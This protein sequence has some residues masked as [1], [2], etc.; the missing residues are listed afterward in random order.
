MSFALSGL[1]LYTMWVVLA[2]IA[3]DFLVT[4]YVSVQSSSFSLSLLASFLNGL[5]HYVFPL[6]ILVNLMPLDPTGWIILIAYYVGAIGVIFKYLID[7]KN[8]L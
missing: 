1:M 2:L 3:V 5:L 4:L 7:I 8:K 6:F